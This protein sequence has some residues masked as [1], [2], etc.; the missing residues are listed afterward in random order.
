MEPAHRD[1]VYWHVRHLQ[2]GPD[3]WGRRCDEHYVGECDRENPRD[4]RAKSDWSAQAR[5]SLAVY[6]GGCHPHR[7]RRRDWSACGSRVHLADSGG[8]A[9]ASGA[10][11][12][13]LGSIWALRR[14]RSW[15]SVWGLPRMESGEPGSDRGATLRI[16]V[17]DR[18]NRADPC[19]ILSSGSFR[20]SRSSASLPA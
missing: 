3:R 19:S 2:R 17:T 1:V 12:G 9:V 16:V 7:H 18:R 13:I 10:L 14:C 11:V 8:M 15:T 4:R 6:V 20:T 5:Y